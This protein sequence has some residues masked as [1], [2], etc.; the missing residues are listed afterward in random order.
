MQTT[1]NLTELLPQLTLEE[2]IKMIHAAG[3]FRTDGIE[4][5][6]IPG[7]HMSDG[8]NGVRQEF[9]DDAWQTVDD[10]GSGGTACAAGV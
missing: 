7:L 10:G 8:P 4:R 3:L 5:L 1:E 6:G 2:K 9:E